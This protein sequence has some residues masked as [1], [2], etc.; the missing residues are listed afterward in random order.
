MR[1]GVLRLRFA[2]QKRTRVLEARWRGL[3]SSEFKR[4]KVSFCRDYLCLW[5][6]EEAVRV[7]GRVVG[8]ARGKHS[9]KLH[10]GDRMFIWAT[11]SDELYLLGAIEV[12]RSGTDWAKGKSLHGP[13][14]IIPLD[15]LKSQLRFMNTGATALRDDRPLVMQVRARRQPTLQTAE[16]LQS[17]LRAEETHE[18]SACAVRE[19]KQRVMTLTKRERNRELRT[20]LL[21]ARGH[22]CEACGFDFAERY[23]EF[24]KHCVEVHHLKPISRSGRHGAMTSL[25]DLKVVCPNCHRALHQ[26]RNPPDW[27][28]FTKLCKS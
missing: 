24:A 21:T 8:T 16:I 1:L 28:A 5:K 23:G 3:H 19:G 22:T 26:H 2:N 14:K 20:D 9:G 15:G 12:A 18:R 25:D 7:K 17:L 10:P 13:F 6:W 4:Q 11:R 27:S